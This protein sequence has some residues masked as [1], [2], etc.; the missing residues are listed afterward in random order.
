MSNIKLNQ[1]RKVQDR[2]ECLICGEIFSDSVQFLPC[3]R[4]TKSFLGNGTLLIEVIGK[5][6][7]QEATGR[8]MVIRDIAFEQVF[9]QELPKEKV[10]KVEVGILQRM[11]DH[12]RSA[13]N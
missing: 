10:V 6:D 8:I 13:G 7:K 12:I 1:N 3:K 5:G 2:K 11:E 9:N 4:C